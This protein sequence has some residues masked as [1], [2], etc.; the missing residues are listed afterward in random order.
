MRHALDNIYSLDNIYITD[1]SRGE[2]VIVHNCDRAKK[3]TKAKF[4]FLKV[5]GIASSIISL[6]NANSMYFEIN[7]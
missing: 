4:H 3:C 5:K 7:P 2:I 6:T 1:S